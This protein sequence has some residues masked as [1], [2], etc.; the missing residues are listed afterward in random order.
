MAED[1]EQKVKI[2]YETNADE[3]SKQT[4]GLASATDDVTQSQ[5][6]ATKATKS[7]SDALRTLS[8]ALS[9]TVDG[10]K[11]VGKS[12]YALLA[13]PIVLF[14]AAIVAGLALL[15]K[16]FASTNDGADKME[17]I[18]AG[19]GAVIDVIRD[20]IL[21][22]GEVLKK[23]W[24]G[25]FVG[26]IDSAKEAISGFGDEV[27]AEFKKAAEVKRILQE[28]DDAVRNLGVSRAKL[29]RD[30]AESKEII[31]DETA[32][33]VEKK[34]A[35]EAVRIAEEK[36]TNAELENAKRKLK[37]IQ[38]ANA[39]SD[40]SDEDL[41][42]EADAEAA[43]YQLQEK[44]ATDRRNIRKIE[45]RADKE[46]LA[47]LKQIS[48][49]RK[50]AQK[51]RIADAKEAEK[52]RQDIINTQLKAEE[53]LTRKIQDLNDKSGQ[54]KLDRQK[55]RDIKELKALEQ[56]GIDIT[57]ALRLND[58]KYVLLQEEL[59]IKNAEIEA[60]RKKKIDDDKLEADKVL[61]DKEIA[62][63]RA[64]L[65]YKSQLQ[66]SQINLAE[67]AAGFLSAI[68]GKNKTLQKASII[69]DLA[70]GTSKAVISNTA[71]NIGALA[72]PQAIATSGASAVPVIAYNNVSTALGIG[73]SVAAAAKALGAI[74]GGGGATSSGS[75]SSSGGSPGSASPQV[76]FQG[77]SEN[78]ISDGVANKINE[79]PP[80]KTFVVASDVTT[81]Q[82][83]ENNAVSANSLAGN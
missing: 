56:K 42:K 69:A 11:S 83:L 59:D 61:K 32:S 18:F 7:Q 58:E 15:Y 48:D 30:L 29:N 20:R 14:I 80:I 73:T 64:L 10:I 47:R 68:A 54:E 8:P 60:A 1:L 34:K 49:E 31:T 23:F 28:I 50:A 74:G 77:S 37:A 78:Q 24:T 82:N 63:E 65:E 52:A 17:Q 13:N 44:S 55:E 39:L 12:L 16:A 41:Q 71:A 40:T 35:I 76:S 25:D 22:Y 38:D 79:L 36:Q 70:V 46:E 3:V 53:D 26:A 33:Y 57:N 5:T 72:T 51:Q 62:A 81:A 66:S 67:K 43:L 75:P 19:L 6:K 45:A 27:L 9:D 2:T 4:E 21:K